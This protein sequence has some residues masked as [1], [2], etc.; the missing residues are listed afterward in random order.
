MP[1]SDYVEF[2]SEVLRRFCFA[3]QDKVF[4][5]Y[6]VHDSEKEQYQGAKQELQNRNDWVASAHEPRENK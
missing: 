2:P 4:C 3:I 5:N 6:H 1:K